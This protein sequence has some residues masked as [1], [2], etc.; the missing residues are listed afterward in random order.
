VV[1]APSIARQTHP[2]DAAEKGR[3]KARDALTASFL[4]MAPALVGFH[5]FTF[6]WKGMT[7]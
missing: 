1:S 5:G 3:R 7:A 2:Q 4:T 6:L